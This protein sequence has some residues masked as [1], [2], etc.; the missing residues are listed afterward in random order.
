[1]VCSHRALANLHRYR[2]Y[3]VSFV[4]ALLTSVQT[5]LNP[6]ITS[7]FGKHGL[8]TSVTI[9]STVLSGCS[10]LTL[11]KIIDIWGRI[12]GF[13]FMLLIIVIGLIMKAT[14]Q[15]IETYVAAHTLFWC[16]HIGMLVCSC[17]G[18]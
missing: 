3:L 2:L 15:N 16:G 7:S 10:K 14:C 11:A 6:Y 17:L 5:S 1:M 18:S 4:D 13:L 12:E 8:L 9:I